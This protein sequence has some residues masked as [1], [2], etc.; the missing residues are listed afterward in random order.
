MKYAILALGLL[1]SIA[2]AEPTGA[3]EG[4]AIFPSAIDPKYVDEEPVRAS[5]H[6]CLE[7]YENNQSTNAN[8]GLKWIQRGGGYYIKCLKRLT[9]T[10]SAPALVQDRGEKLERYTTEECAWI[11]KMLN[12]CTLAVVGRKAC[13][14][15]I[16]GNRSYFW[17]LEDKYPHDWGFQ[18]DCHD[19]DAGKFVCDEGPAVRQIYDMCQEVCNGKTNPAGRPPEVLPPAQDLDQ[20][21][22]SL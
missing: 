22:L 1:T 11:E 2:L 4:D 7:Q 5:M 14:P 6:T 20:P 15:M 8:G 9:G 13:D 17:L 3:A 21:A 19:N 10:S 12:Q 18:V 16:P